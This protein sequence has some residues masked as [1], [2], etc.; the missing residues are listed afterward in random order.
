[1]VT[2]VIPLTIVAAATCA[3]VSLAYFTRGIHAY[4][5]IIFIVY[6]LLF[7]TFA[8]ILVYFTKRTGVGATSTDHS[9]DKASSN[10]QS[11]QVHS[12]LNN[13]ANERSMDNEKAIKFSSFTDIVP[14]SQSS[15]A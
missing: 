10:K 1:M 14:A 11:P 13:T 12:D 15:I 3:A 2:F 8:L 4:R 7:P 5:F 6:S 9:N